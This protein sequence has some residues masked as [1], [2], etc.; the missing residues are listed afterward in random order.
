MVDTME[1]PTSVKDLVPGVDD[2]IIEYAKNQ[3]FESS[4]EVIVGSGEV[5]YENATAFILSVSELSSICEGKTSLYRD[6]KLLSEF[7]TENGSN[8]YFKLGELLISNLFKGK[9]DNNYINE[10]YLKGSV[11]SAEFTV[12][13][14]NFANI[15]ADKDIYKYLELKV[16]LSDVS[17]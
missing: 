2:I 12:D 10:Y 9:Y 7:I 6:D 4:Y 17:N 15:I 14:S 11:I 16:T 1:V 3:I 8:S 13:P 5:D